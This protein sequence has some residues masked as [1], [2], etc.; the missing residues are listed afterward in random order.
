MS[1]YLD[2]LSII[3][4]LKSD[5][6][7]KRAYF[8]KDR[9]R[10]IECARMYWG[11]DYGQYPAQ[12][13]N[14]LLEQGRQ[15]PTLNVMANKMDGLRGSLLRNQFDMKYVPI[16]G[17]LDE[18]SL[19][20]QDMYYSDKDDMNWDFSYNV[21]LRDFL[22]QYG[23]EWMH[24]D[25]E[26]SPFGNIAF[27]PD[28]A[29]NH[30]PD[31]GWKTPFIKDLRNLV[32][33]G[34][35]TAEELK[36]IYPKKDG[37]LREA[38][39]RQLYASKSEQY[40]QHET[41][42]PY[43]NIDH[44]WGSK[45]RVIERHEIICKNIDWEYNVRDGEWFPETGFKPGTPEDRAS[46]EH[47][48]EQRG[49]A[50][51]DDIR[52]LPKKDR[53][54]H[55]KTICD[56]YDTVLE[57]KDS[58]IQIGYIPCFMTGPAKMGSQWRGLGDLS[59]D[60]QQNLNKYLM[61][62]QEILDRSARGGMFINER[63]VSG[64]DHMKQYVESH[65]NDSSPRIWVKPDV[66]D[67][68]KYIKEFPASHIPNDLMAFH[69]LMNDYSDKLT[70]QTPAAEGRSESSKESGK[71]FQSKFEAHVIA[72]G[73]IDKALEMHW[74]AKAEAYLA[75]SKITYS[76]VPREFS[77]R[78][79][80]K[81]FII[82]EQVPV[83]LRNDISKLGRHRVILVPSDKG[84]DV[85]INQRGIF[86]ELKNTTRD[87]LMAADYDGRIIET[88]E[89]SDDYKAEFKQDI[90]LIKEEARVAKKFNILQMTVQ[91]QQLQAQQQAQQGQQQQVEGGG[92]PPQITQGGEL[93]LEQGVQGTPLEGDLQEIEDRVAGQKNV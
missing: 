63:I 20:I 4:D 76:G 57:D 64:D 92:P 18:L 14:M 36:E 88:L 89:M 29:Y 8:E 58:I 42:P 34:W 81:R 74:H 9:A 5:F 39:L 33:V 75:Q 77:T 45:Q 23:V 82:N 13:V 30:Y 73:A 41:G 21:F 84:V 60:I 38:Y 44:I 19:A 35:Y 37:E 65:W 70:Y 16:S 55:I 71:L 54:Y 68:S 61:M 72:R 90:E 87:P 11:L 85:R 80:K 12:V 46:K 25:T 79:G 31:P 17:E 32:K 62:M 6:E 69:T 66:D 26:N 91:S 53:R 50:R 51:V 40:Q 67:M 78:D 3:N 15:V 47:Y 22:I 24:I 49:L 43:Q 28:I 83:G 2:N 59:K 86:V 27:K 1:S 10:Y 7:A 48:I 52:W 56:A 93:S